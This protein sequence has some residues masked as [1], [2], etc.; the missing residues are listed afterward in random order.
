MSRAATK[1]R[2]RTMRRLCQVPAEGERFFD[3]WFADS[4]T[5]AL[6]QAKLL[7]NNDKVGGPLSQVACDVC[8]EFCFVYCALMKALPTLCRCTL[9]TCTGYRGM[10]YFG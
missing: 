1:C 9:P 8:T 5:R 4:A 3:N 10:A 6:I 7:D 2:C